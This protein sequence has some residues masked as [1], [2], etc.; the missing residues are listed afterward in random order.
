MI[1]DYELVC[2]LRKFEEINYK[3]VWIIYEI[4]KSLI[5]GYRVREM[6]GYLV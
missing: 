1:Y 6:S 3:K 5:S 2:L 4:E